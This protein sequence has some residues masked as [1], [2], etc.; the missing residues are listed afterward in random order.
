MCSPWSRRGARWAPSDSV[1]AARLSPAEERGELVISVRPVKYSGKKERDDGPIYLGRHV[2]L[3]VARHLDWDVVSRDHLEN[4]LETL[5][6][7][8]ETFLL[9]NKK[10]IT[11]QTSQTIVYSPWMRE[12]SAWG[13]QSISDRE[14]NGSTRDPSRMVHSGYEK[15]LSIERMTVLYHERSESWTDYRLDHEIQ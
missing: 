2:D 6:W 11:S 4:R 1:R 10:L 5:L 15:W 7:M 13:M 8:I 9:N 3:L 12:W 14:E